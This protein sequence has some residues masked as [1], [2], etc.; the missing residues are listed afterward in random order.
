MCS[1]CKAESLK[2]EVSGKRKIKDKGFI[3]YQLCKLCSSMLSNINP[4]V[5]SHKRLKV[6]DIIWDNAQLTC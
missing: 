2:F 4:R 5:D 3:K 1:Y 6:W